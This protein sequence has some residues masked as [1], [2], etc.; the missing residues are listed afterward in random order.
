MNRQRRRPAYAYALVILLITMAFMSLGATTHAGIVSTTDK[1]PDNA[2]ANAIAYSS[3]T[4]AE[5]ELTPAPT[6]DSLEAEEEAEEEELPYG[7][8]D[9][10]TVVTPEYVVPADSCWCNDSYAGKVLDIDGE[11]YVCAQAVFT[12][13]LDGVR[14]ET[15]EDFFSLSAEGLS[16]T[17]YFGDTWFVCN[18]RYFYAPNGIVQENGVVYLPAS[19]VARCFGAECAVDEESGVLYLNVGK[20][21]LP[22]DGD[23]Y[24]DAEALYWLSRCISAEAGEEPMEGQ[25]AVGNVILNRLAV[26]YAGA[27]TVKEVIF[28]AGQFDVVARGSIYSRPQED[29]VIAAKLALDG[30]EVMPDALYFAVGWLGEGYTILGWIDNHCF[31][32]LA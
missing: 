11:Y 14:F 10:D 3:E 4:D 1:T 30:A 24:Y 5:N 15:A 6:A 20:V 21:I 17:A 7:Q 22:E 8:F 19:A 28:S 31:Q 12:S 27:T 26:G 2:S 32:T 23:S 18:N 29:S 16:L 9:P 13:M 25:I